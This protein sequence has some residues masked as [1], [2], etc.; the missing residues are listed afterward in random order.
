MQAK[1]MVKKSRKESRRD[2]CIS[3]IS[4]PKMATNPITLL[5]VIDESI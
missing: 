4:S 3:L 1:R 2:E 5:A